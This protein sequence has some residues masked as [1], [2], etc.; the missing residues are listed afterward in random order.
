[1]PEDTPTLQMPLQQTPISNPAKRRKRDALPRRTS[2][3]ACS[4]ARDVPETEQLRSWRSFFH[5]KL[6]K[7]S[8]LYPCGSRITGS[9][10]DAYSRLS[11]PAVDLIA[12]TVGL[13]EEWVCVDFGCG[14]G[15]ALLQLHH[16]YHCAR[17]LGLEKQSH[18][19]SRAQALCRHLFPT[20]DEAVMFQEVDVLDASAATPVI[21]ASLFR[22]RAPTRLFA[23]VNNVNYGPLLNQA[24]ANILHGVQDR[25][26][27]TQV[28]VVS[29]QALAYGRAQHLSAG[30]KWMQQACETVFKHREMQ[31]YKYGALEWRMLTWSDCSSIQALSENDP[32]NLPASSLEWCSDSDSGGSYMNHAAVSAHPFTPH[33]SVSFFSTFRG[34]R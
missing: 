14:E 33:L 26:R 27:S 20:L 12:Q 23:L 9:G 29:F 13:S 18:L 15:V 11:N 28:T 17:F 4:S 7:E 8:S 30:E 32:M 31:K 3:A 5:E 1:M 25:H 10:E 22:E 16:A 24:I 21:E 19:V 34:V 2:L 6:S